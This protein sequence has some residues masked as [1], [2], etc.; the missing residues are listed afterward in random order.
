MCTGERRLSSMLHS[1]G[2]GSWLSPP[3]LTAP[4]PKG[5][6]G[7]GGGRTQGHSGWRGFCPGGCGPWGLPGGVIMGI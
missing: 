6:T 4:G 7:Q 3:G 5:M 2:W 1:R